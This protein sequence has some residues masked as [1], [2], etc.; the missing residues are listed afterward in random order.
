M[1]LIYDKDSLEFKIKKLPAV[2]RTYGFLEWD[3]SSCDDPLD[4][5]VSGLVQ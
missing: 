3:S 2:R 1:N 5:K 4:E